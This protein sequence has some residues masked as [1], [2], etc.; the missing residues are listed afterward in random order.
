MASVNNHLTQASHNKDFLNIIWPQYPEYPDWVVT[1]IFYVA[2]HLLEAYFDKQLS[3]SSHDYQDREDTITQTLELRPIYSHYNELKRLSM[4]SR[5]HC[6]FVSWT[7]EKVR[8]ASFHLNKI[9]AHLE[10]L[11]R[12]E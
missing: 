11:L 6:K 7:P 4:D 9:E 1:V 2:I 8:G 10:S 3:K 12:E 5:Y